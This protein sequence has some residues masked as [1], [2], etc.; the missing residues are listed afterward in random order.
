MRENFGMLLPPSLRRPLQ[1]QQ[2]KK[3]LKK[4][5]RKLEETRPIAA[6]NA[7]CKSALKLRRLSWA[8]SVRRKRD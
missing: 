8:G 7:V 4:S 3:I 5:G 2:K 6:Y 1:Q